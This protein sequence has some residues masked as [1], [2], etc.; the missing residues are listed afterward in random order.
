M[1]VRF[2]ALPLEP[3]FATDEADAPVLASECASPVAVASP[4]P[5]E[6]PEFPDVAAPPVVEAEPRMDVLVAVGATV[7]GPVPPVGPESPD[8]AVGLDD[9]VEAASPVLPEFVA[10]D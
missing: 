5:P 2:T 10:D 7:A 3:V 4:V 6:L 1:S 8:R 9:A